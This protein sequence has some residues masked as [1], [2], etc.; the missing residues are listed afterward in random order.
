[1]QCTGMQVLCAQSNGGPFP[2]YIYMQ[3][4]GMQGIYAGLT[5]GSRSSS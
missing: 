5:G 1:M 4:S 2:F 3:C